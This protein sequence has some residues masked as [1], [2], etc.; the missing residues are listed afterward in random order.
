[1]HKCTHS[2][3]PCTGRCGLSTPLI[4]FHPLSVPRFAQMRRHPACPVKQALVLLILSHSNDGTY[5][6]AHLLKVGQKYNT[7]NV[8]FKKKKALYRLSHPPSP[9]H[10][11]L[12]S[13]RLG[14][15][16]HYFLEHLCYC[17][18]ACGNLDCCYCF[19]GGALTPECLLP[20]SLLQVQQPS[21][22]L[23]R[24]PRASTFTP[25]HPPA[26]VTGDSAKPQAA[27]F[28]FFSEAETP[29]PFWK[30]QDM[31]CA[32]LG[33]ARPVRARPRYPALWWLPAAPPALY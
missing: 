4:L 20:T 15:A 10:S 19:P 1:M 30:G 8:T 27:F 32:L 26:V 13:Y 11:G 18:P 22:L 7:Q 33:D 5:W 29:D 28:F 23:L 2:S 24:R 16:L 12:I 9:L 3:P 21:F 31:S 17:E 25:S 6:S 14:Q